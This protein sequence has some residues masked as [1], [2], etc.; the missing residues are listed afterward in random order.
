MA[1]LPNLDFQK[2]TFPIHTLGLPVDG[3][4]SLFISAPLDPTLEILP[5]LTGGP[6]A[7]VPLIDMMLEQ[8]LPV[9][10]TATTYS[11]ALSG[12]TFE[13]TGAG[14]TYTEV[15]GYDLISGGTIDGFSAALNGTPL[16]EA[17]NIAMAAADLYAAYMAEFAGQLDAIETLVFGLDWTFI[18]SD[19]AGGLRPSTTTGDGVEI[20]FA[21]DNIVYMNGGTEDW[22]DLGPGNDRFYGGDG[23]D[24]VTGRDGRDI[25]DGGLAGDIIAGGRGNDILSGGRGRDIIGGEAGRDKIRGGKHDDFIDGGIGND[26]IS[27]GQHNDLLIGG[28]GADQIRGGTGRDVIFGDLGRDRLFGGDGDDLIVAGAGI[29]TMT[30]GAGVDFFA[31]EANDQR[32]TVTDFEDGVDFI[33]FDQD[34]FFTA[35]DTDAGLLLSY[36][37][38]SALLVGMT[39]DRFDGAD[40]STQDNTT[41]YFSLYDLLV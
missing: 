16:L 31:F 15:G 24:V 9:T 26:R 8:A 40:V 41:T 12:Y 7:W 3:A 25:I 17:S 34:L 2:V 33:T 30:G 32:N 29:D 14:L 20:V 27:G 5:G 19:G 11:L 13:I 10:A 18:D 4:A 37:G 21:G 6:G 35:Q 36:D 28:S 38:G 1:K 22:F 23:R 39:V